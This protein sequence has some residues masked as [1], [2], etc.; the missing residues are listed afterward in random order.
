MKKYFI[1][2][3]LIF[4]LLLTSCSSNV[5]SHLAFETPLLK[6]EP[7]NCD[8]TDT[9]Y[10]YVDRQVYDLSVDVNE[11]SEQKGEYTKLKTVH[12][13][14]TLLPDTALAINLNLKSEIPYVSVTYSLESGKTR[15][16]FIYCDQNQKLWL[17]E[18]K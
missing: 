4:A 11:Y 9:V 6:T 5:V 7:L 14:K 13:Q 12:T 3:I 1:T 8:G 15:Q 2:P 10:F 18:Q 16:Q 17:L